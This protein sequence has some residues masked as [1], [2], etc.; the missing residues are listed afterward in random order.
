MNEEKKETCPD[1]PHPKGYPCT[2]CGLN[3]ESTND[4]KE[5]NSK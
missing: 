3:T 5:I 1:C 2:L 4:S